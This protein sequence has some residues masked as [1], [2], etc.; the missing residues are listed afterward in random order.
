MSR[1]LQVH[2]TVAHGRRA[3]LLTICARIILL[4]LLLSQHLLLLHLNHPLLVF[5]RNVGW[6]NADAVGHWDRRADVGTTG[7]RHRLTRRLVQLASVGHGR[8]RL[9]VMSI[10][11]LDGTVNRRPHLIELRLTILLNRLSDLAVTVLLRTCGDHGI[12]DG[13]R[14]RHLPARRKLAWRQVLHAIHWRSGTLRWS[15]LADVARSDPA[16]LRHLDRLSTSERCCQ[17][18]V[19]LS[20]RLNPS[21]RCSSLNL[22]R[23]VR[24]TVITELSCLTH[25][26]SLSLGLGLS[27]SV[28]H[29]QLL[30]FALM[31]VQLRLQ[32]SLLLLEWHLHG[33][34]VRHALNRLRELRR[35][36]PG[37]I[38]R[39][40]FLLGQSEERSDFF[41]DRE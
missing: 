27:L 33:L 38:D 36:G 5:S 1:Q 12:Q 31:L 7:L 14:T 24:L 28:L 6:E 21:G 30:S 41:D 18:R 29:Q 17:L 13:G 19:G 8:G 37:E 9:S 4:R 23:R 20:S 25:S 35:Y 2:L 10:G 3:G 39:G 15:H 26:L 32:V 34:S 22:L 11:D 40:R 16:D